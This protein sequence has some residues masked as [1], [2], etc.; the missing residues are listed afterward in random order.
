[1]SNEPKTAGC[2][3]ASP[4]V[5]SWADP[6]RGLELGLLVKVAYRMEG[7]LRLTRL[8][9]GPPVHLE[10]VYGSRTPEGERQLMHDSDRLAFRKP[11]TDVLLQGS[12]HSTRGSVVELDTGLS[13]GSMRKRVRVRG[14]RRLRADAPGPL[15][16]ADSEGFV[17][18]PL[19]WAHAY[20]GRD[21][22]AERKAARSADAPPEARWGTCAYPRNR[23]GR[24][25]FLD[26]SRERLDGVLLPNLDDPEDPVEPERI[27]AADTLDWADRPLGASY[28]PIDVLT[29]PRCFFHLV[30]PDWRPDS[31]PLREMA[32]GCVGPADLRDRHLAEPP[33]PRVFCCAPAGLARERLRGNERISLW[34][35]HRS[36]EL[37]ELDLP[38]ERPRLLLEP[39]GAGVREMPAQLQTVLIEPDEDRVT[40]TWTGSMPVAA[41]FPESMCREMRHGVIWEK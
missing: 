27:L 22:H 6:A 17:A 32:L 38:A 18:M 34:H 28:G 4:F 40:L 24:G 1:M 23:V 16:A 19:D 30:R 15:G 37:L 10:P 3:A 29:V 31:R 7:D 5:H 14:D 41:V 12:A 20:G 8:P 39:P 36:F 11:C 25:F 21:V 33:D 2:V 26:T 9:E 35:L 13:V